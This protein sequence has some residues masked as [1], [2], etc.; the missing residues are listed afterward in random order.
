MQDNLDTFPIRKNGEGRLA[1]LRRIVNWQQRFKRELKQI[2][3][4]KPLTENNTWVEIE[5]SNGQ[6]HFFINSN[7]FLSQSSN[8]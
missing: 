8:P 4:Q 6:K 5:T 7:E 2:I 1:Y 3:L